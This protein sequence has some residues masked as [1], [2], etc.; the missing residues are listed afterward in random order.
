[1]IPK[2]LLKKIRRIEI[3]TSHLVNDALAGQYHSAFKGR[4]MEF[5]E[6]REY[7]PGDDVR[8]IDWNV[9]ARIGQPYVK[10]FREEREL[11]VMLVVDLSASQSF[12]T[13][14]QFKRELVA[15]IGATLAFSAIKN[16]DTV[17][18]LCFT[19]RVEKFVPPRKGASHVLRVIRELLVHQPA[20]RGTNI[21]L[22]LGHLN[23]ITRKRSV[24]FVISDFLDEGFEREL[25]AAR[26]RHDLILVRVRDR[27]EVAM[28]RAGLITLIDNENGREVVVDTRSAAWQRAYTEHVEAN[29]GI[30]D[31]SAAIDEGGLHRGRDRAVVRR[32][33]RPLLPNPG[34]ATM[35]RF[36][37][38]ILIFMVALGLSSCA[39][40]DKPAESTT[41]PLETITE[42][43]PLALRVEASAETVLAGDILTVVVG[44]TVPTGYEV[45]MPDLLTNEALGE[46]T[47]R[48]ARRPPD[49]PDGDLRRWQHTYDLDTFATGE[50]EIPSFEVR[51]APGNGAP[52][53]ATAGVLI[54]EP[55]AITVRSV[56]GPDDADGSFRNIR[57]AVDADLPP[58]R[59]AWRTWGLVALALIIVAALARAWWTR[60]R[61]GA[62]VEPPPVPPGEWARAALERLEADGLIESARFTEF[63]DRLSA[64]VREYVERRFGLMAPERTTD[65][66]LREAGHSELLSVGHRQLLEGFLRSAD[67]IK[68]AR[69]R[70][71]VD[72]CRTALDAA[73]TFVHETAD[74]SAPDTAD[75]EP[76]PC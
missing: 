48:D 22:A 40:D 17:G 29:R 39:Q 24:V 43:G 28:P 4:G 51:Y 6:V 54:S 69:Q 18:L 57:A 37:A 30:V 74:D 11:T 21:G 65:E 50:I 26:R 34:G 62:V 68:F 12:G 5:E 19:D 31:S 70:S 36:A 20:G 13:N 55:L 56:L 3:R 58:T 2:E 32:S 45:E 33:T 59:P 46:F 60:G 8:T 10:K 7:Q 25:R 47:V 72:E 71:S 14:D 15:E 35:T 42:R 41:A 63:F 61:E 53:G 27:H 73:E 9:S 38:S 49:I 76:A 75:P 66:F 52:A 16:N 44:V 64:I 1:M 23:R 67:M